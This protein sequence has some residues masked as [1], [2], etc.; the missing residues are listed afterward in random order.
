[1]REELKSKL[2]TLPLKPGCY[3]MKDKDGKII[4]VG[5]AIKLKNRV[6]SYFRGAHDY[7]TTKLVSRIYD[8]DYI[9]TNSEKEALI[10]EYNLIKEYDPEFNIIFKDDKSYPYILLSDDEIPYCKTVRLKK[11]SK[12]K[13]KIFGPYPDV[14]AANNTIALINKLFKTRKCQNLKK[15]LCLY[16]H[17]GLCLG[18]CQKDVPKEEMV[19]IKNEIERFLKGDNSKVIADLK[20]N[21]QKATES[22]RFEEAA[23]YRD[24]ISDIEYVTN[25]RQSVQ[26][27]RSEN[28][29]TFNYFVEDNYIS[30][31]GL[32]IRHGRLLSRSVHIAHLY[33]D[34]EEEFISY[35]YQFYQ[36]NL[37]PKYLV[38]DHVLNLAMLEE[39]LN[40]E[41]RYFNRGFKYQMLNKAKENAKENL[42]QKKQI[43]KKDE[44]YL[45]IIA[46]EFK[47]YLGFTPERVEL[48]DNSHLSGESTCAA[49]VVYQKLRPDKKEYRLYRLEDG[50]DDLKSMHEV[51]YRRY[52]KVLNEG[53]KRP[54]LILIDGGE[55]QMKVALDILKSL[56]LSIKVWGLKKDDK[57]ATSI[58]LDEDLKPIEID[59][60]SNIFLY[61]A[62][63]QDE[64]HRFAITYNRKL[65]QKKTYASKLDGIKGLG[66][67]R[68]TLLL[69]KF[70]SIA[71]LKTRSIEELST[72]IPENVAVLVYNKLK[73][74]M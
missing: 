18:Y 1:M 4:Y 35:I 72:V 70:K 20:M 54:D 66:P 28:F 64:V 69:R 37:L 48:F 2:L 3:L 29:D 21:M 49:M 23:K 33:G 71:N 12:Y 27:N 41:V 45:E 42:R 59:K 32:F 67:K 63:M 19:A 57:H 15:E 40:I 24:L 39:S 74:D 73:E 62:S 30:I 65:R 51:L 5:K 68:R 13:G 16:Y 17:M 55:N 7:K 38:L 22:L 52:F 11:K 36:N 50:Y 6:N 46:M 25:E 31:V 8:F 9:V 10:L 47:K 58:I 60:S 56:D 14:S 43:I 53:L 26:G 44:H 34:P 61:L